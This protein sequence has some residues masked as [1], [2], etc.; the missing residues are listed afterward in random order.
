MVLVAGSDLIA[1][2][3][4]AAVQAMRGQIDLATAPP[5]FPI[6]D[7]T[8]DLV[9]HKRLDQDPAQQWFRGVLLRC[10]ERVVASGLS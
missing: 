5:P 9:W 6:A 7:F 4:K 1:I 3:P 10:A 2:L 8:Y